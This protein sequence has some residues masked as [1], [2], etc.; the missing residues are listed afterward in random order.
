MKRCY[1]FHKDLGLQLLALYLFLIIPFLVTLWGFDSFVGERIQNDVTS[2]DLSLARAVAQQAE[3]S[4]RNALIAVEEL[5]NFPG[6]VEAD[7]DAMDYLFG[8]VLDTRPD[9]N[10]VYRLVS[11]GV[12]L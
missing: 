5:A 3:Y 9:L 8:V 7:V 10:L 11:D 12:M 4:V 6:V 2:N 1:R